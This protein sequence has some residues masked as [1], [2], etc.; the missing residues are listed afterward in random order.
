MQD[1][2]R[3]DV[4]TDTPGLVHELFSKNEGWVGVVGVVYPEV[5]VYPFYTVLYLFPT[6]NS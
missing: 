6:H 2:Q 1:M 5:G 4:Y 3:V